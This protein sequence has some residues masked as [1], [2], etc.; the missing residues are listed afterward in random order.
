MSPAAL[1][2]LRRRCVPAAAALIAAL[3][4]NVTLSACSALAPI[5]DDA[6]YYVLN[7][8]AVADHGAPPLADVVVGVGPI[9][10]PQYLDRSEMVVRA[11][12]SQIV[13]LPNARW[14]EPLA[15]NFG[16][17]L[18]ED[19][20][21]EL[22]TVQV[23]VFPWYA[24]IQPTYGVAM[25][26]QRFELADD[27]E[28][29]LQARWIVRRLPERTVAAVRETTV[30]EPAVR[31][32]PGSIAAA[33]SR[34]VAALGKEVAVAIRGAKRSA[35]KGASSPPASRARRSAHH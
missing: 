30:A 16:H 26:V 12:D 33:M 4:A 3:A 20:A 22:G 5:R 35:A 28:V 34:A 1:D 10:M 17:V 13:A 7:A 27:G 31:S 18:A 11:G 14:G 21:V 2:L 23:V 19:L 9:A 29:H 25:D 15:P 32:D 8:V 6:R 24:A